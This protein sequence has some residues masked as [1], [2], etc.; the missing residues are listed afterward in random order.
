MNKL[1]TKQK[2]YMI[3]YSPLT[4][5][6]ELNGNY[7]W[8][9]PFLSII[10]SFGITTVLISWL[11]KDIIADTI[12][13]AL[14]EKG[15]NPSEIEH[16]VNLATGPFGL[17]I[18]GISTI[19]TM[20]LVFVLIAAFFTFVIKLIGGKA[21][22]KKIISI[23]SYSSIVLIA[24]H[25]LTIVGTVIAPDQ[26]FDTSLSVFY[27][28]FGNNPLYV[29]ILSQINIFAIW[30]FVLFSLGLSLICKIKKIIS[31]SLVFSSWTIYI[32]LVVTI[33]K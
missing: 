2:M 26:T 25:V 1:S 30:Q 19:F 5:F 12:T 13:Y 4:V 8:G 11:K 17:F 6:S 28:L 23:Y 9:F 32:T 10:M 14:T 24:G 15:L 3:F 7:D 27:T 29:K 20:S 22:F 16:A 18:S 21:N 31:F 33:F